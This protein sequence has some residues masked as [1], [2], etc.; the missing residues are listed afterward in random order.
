MLAEQLYGGWETYPDIKKSHCEMDQDPEFYPRRFNEDSPRLF[1][2]Q[3]DQLESIRVSDNKGQ[4]SN[5][6]ALETRSIG[7]GFEMCLLS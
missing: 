1:S 4:T 2:T 5:I 6:P 3:T 7:L